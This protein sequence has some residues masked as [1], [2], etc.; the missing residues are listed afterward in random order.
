MGQHSSSERA[1]C[2]LAILL[3][4]IIDKIATLLNKSLRLGSRQGDKNLLDHCTC[5]VSSISDGKSAFR[6]PASYYARGKTPLP[7]GGSSDDL[8]FVAATIST[9]EQNR[10]RGFQEGEALQNSGKMHSL[11]SLGPERRKKDQKQH[12]HPF[13]GFKWFEP[14]RSY[15]TLVKAAAVEFIVEN[16]IEAFACDVKLASAHDTDPHDHKSPKSGGGNCEVQRKD[17]P[18]KHRGFHAGTALFVFLA[19][20]SVTSGCHSKDVAAASGETCWCH[21]AVNM[22]GAVVLYPPPHPPS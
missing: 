9:S 11:K 16:C 10:E 4:I 22:G 7:V 3:S 19:T 18:L 5:S 17:I 1:N 20:G 6:R 2:R 12:R 14:A 8:N 13:K 21:L 15:R